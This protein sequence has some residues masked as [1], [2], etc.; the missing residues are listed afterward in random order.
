MSK[1]TVTLLVGLVVFLLGTIIGQQLPAIQAQPKTAPPKDAT[2]IHGFNLRI[3]GVGEQ[4]FTA[5]S[6]RIPVEVFRDENNGNVIYISEAGSIA[7][8]PGK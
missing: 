2:P 6:K 3:R 8:V 7:V 4:K 5:D 1:R